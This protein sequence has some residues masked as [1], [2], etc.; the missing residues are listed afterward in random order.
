MRCLWRPVS[1]IPSG[2]SGPPASQNI[3]VIP[4]SG[5]DSPTVRGVLVAGLPLI[6]F[7][8]IALDISA[9]IE[10]NFNEKTFSPE[11][12][13][14]CSLQVTYFDP[15]P[16]CEIGQAGNFFHIDPRNRVPV[17]P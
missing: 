7:Y 1:R 9:R 8:S 15:Y 12:S 4:A 17:L 14:L 5:I 11:K 16:R 6:H 3:H 10:R 13:P 2:N